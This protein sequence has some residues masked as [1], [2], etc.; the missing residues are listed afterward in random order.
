MAVNFNNLLNKGDFRASLNEDWRDWIK[1]VNGFRTPGSINGPVGLNKIGLLFRHAL[2]MCWSCSSHAKNAWPCLRCALLGI[3]F[4]HFCCFGQFNSRAKRPVS[5]APVIEQW[6]RSKSM[7]VRWVFQGCTGIQL[8]IIEAY[9]TDKFA[10]I[11]HIPVHI[12][13]IHFPLNQAFFLSG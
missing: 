6:S 11:K 1:Y 10:F 2:K 8:W 7:T 3:T 4:P 9:T 12:R 5:M 13:K